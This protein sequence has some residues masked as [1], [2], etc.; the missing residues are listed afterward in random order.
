MRAE[1]P[2]VEMANGLSDNNPGSTLVVK[3]ECL[4]YIGFGAEPTFYIF[5]VAIQAVATL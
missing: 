3:Q 1:R 5:G 2:F 4:T